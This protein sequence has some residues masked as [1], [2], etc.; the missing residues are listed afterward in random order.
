MSIVKIVFILLSLTLAVFAKD[1]VVYENEYKILKLQNKIKKLVV[2]NK[3][4]L[5]VS[6]LSASANTTHL[7]LFGKKSGNTS[8]LIINRDGS[9]DNYHVYINQNLGYLQKMVNVIEP[10]IYLSRVGNGSVI[11]SGEFKTLIKKSVFTLF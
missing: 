1:I 10:D 11:I 4:I 3:D 8:I 7:K 6:L 9:Y 2:G 5:N